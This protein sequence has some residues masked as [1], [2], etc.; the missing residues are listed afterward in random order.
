MK[1]MYSI[2]IQTVGSVLY[3]HELLVSNS[4]CISKKLRSQVASFNDHIIDIYIYK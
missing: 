4:T 2:S 3:V 1:I